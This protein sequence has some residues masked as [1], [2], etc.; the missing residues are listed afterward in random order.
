MKV[1]EKSRAMRT[2]VVGGGDAEIFVFP[3]CPLAEYA[4][5][6]EDPPD[7]QMPS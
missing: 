6:I 1:E 7:L 2:K 4:K 3:R 5:D